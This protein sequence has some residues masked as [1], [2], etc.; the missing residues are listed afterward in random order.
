MDTYPEQTPVANGA[1]TKVK[2]LEVTTQTKPDEPPE[3]LTTSGD[4]TITTVQGVDQPRLMTLREPTEPPL[5]STESLEQMEDVVKGAL[6][7][8]EEAEAEWDEPGVEEP[9]KTHVMENN[10]VALNQETAFDT[11]RQSDDVL[12][13]SQSPDANKL[14]D[15]NNYLKPGIVPYGEH[16]EDQGSMDAGYHVQEHASLRVQIPGHIPDHT[17]YK[18]NNNMNTPYNT[19]LKV[20]PITKQE[21]SQQG[22]PVVPV[23]VRE[24]SNYPRT[25]DITDDST[26]EAQKEDYVQKIESSLAEQLFIEDRH[27]QK[28]TENNQVNDN[29]EPILSKNILDT[30]EQLQNMAANANV[31]NQPGIEPIKCENLRKPITA[32]PNSTIIELKPRYP[33]DWQTIIE[34]VSLVFSAHRDPRHFHVIRIHVFG[35]M[36]TRVL[37][38]PIKRRLYCQL[39]TPDKLQVVVAGNTRVMTLRNEYV[40]L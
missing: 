13:M 2:Y 33:D 32:L 28:N 5:S 22:I 1:T 20:N 37:Q 31:A 14:Y 10:Q 30:K 7:L 18:Q 11:S 9:I 25:F 38:D 6:T 12:G 16:M 27:A 3:P 8:A 15:R 35:I 21:L 4:M 23:A 17:Y 19:A 36:L 40:N 34:N 26:L 29:I 39:W 24:S